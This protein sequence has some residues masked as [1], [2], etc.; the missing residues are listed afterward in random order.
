[1]SCCPSTVPWRFSRVAALPRECMAWQL[2]SCNSYVKTR[3]LAPH[4]VFTPPSSRKQPP[5]TDTTQQQHSAT[6]PAR[7]Q[8][9]ASKIPAPAA[10]CIHSPCLTQYNTNR[11][12]RYEFIKHNNFHGVSVGLIRRFAIQLLTSLRFLRKQRIIHCD[13]KPE[14]ILLKQPNKSGIKV[15]GL[16]SWRLLS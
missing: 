8:K 16:G 3:P 15:T 7:P 4:P 10:G 5:T 1:M 13:L 9:Q 2:P 11:C 12:G 6:S 14:N